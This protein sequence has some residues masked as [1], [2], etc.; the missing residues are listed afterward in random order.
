MKQ[1]KHIW[2]YIGLDFWCREHLHSRKKVTS[3]CASS[4]AS[5]KRDVINVLGDKGTWRYIQSANPG[6]VGRHP[7][8]TNYEDPRTRTSLH[9]GITQ[10]KAVGELTRNFRVLSAILGSSHASRNSSRSDITYPQ[11]FAHISRDIY[12]TWMPKAVS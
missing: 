1:M 11:S 7:T 6:E 2:Q 9:E 10:C 5:Q 12:P 8:I 4:T 3:H